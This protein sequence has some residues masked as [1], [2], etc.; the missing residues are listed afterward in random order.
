MVQRRIACVTL[1]L[2]CCLAVGLVVGL[3][4]GNGAAAAPVHVFACEPE[5]AALSREIGGGQVSVYTAVQPLQDAHQIQAR[6]A[7]IARMRSA[8]LVFCNGADLEIGWLP[9]LLM[10]SA[11]PGVQPG[12][13]GLLYAADQ[14]NLIEVPRSVDRAEG[15]LHPRGNPHVQLDPRNIGIVAEAL[16][17]HLATL[18]PDGAAGYR[19]RLDDFQR[20][21]QQAAGRWQTKAAPLKGLPVLP[22]TK[23]YSYLLAWLD[24]SE[25]AILEPKPGVPPS[26]AHLGELTRRLERQRPRMVIRGAFESA[27]AADWVAERLGIPSVVLPFTVGG[28]ERS[29]DL[30]ALFDDTLERLLAAAR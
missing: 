5:W 28:T 23:S 15:D 24:M 29:G 19:S 20:R 2:A 4:G 14:V 13:P 8:Q 11:N 6:P 1:A 12:T 10:N 25:V 17:Q 21:W 7:L 3:P 9:L 18:D 30:F 16:A 26:M 27:Q 22:A